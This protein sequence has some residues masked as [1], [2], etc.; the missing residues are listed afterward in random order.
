M[1]YL[2]VGFDDVDLARMYNPSLTTIRQPFEEQGDLAIRIMIDMI[3]KIIH[4]TMKKMK[5][6]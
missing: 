3:E 6:L 5:N 2:F 1:T 4:L